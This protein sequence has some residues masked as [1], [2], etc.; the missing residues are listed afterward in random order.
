MSMIFQSYALWPHMTVTENVAYGLTLRRRPR[1]EIAKKVGAHPRHHQAVGAGRS[2][3]RRTVGRPAAARRARPRADRRAG[4]AAARRAAVQSRRQS[5]R[6]DALRGAPAA[7]RVP[8]HDGLRHPRPVGGDDHRRPDR[9]DERRQDRAGRHAG[10]D[11]RPA[12]L[13][14]RRP[15]HRLEQHRQGQGARPAITSRWRACRCAASARELIAGEDTAVSMRQH[16]ISLST[17]AAGS[18]STTS[19][20]QPSCATSF[21][22]TAATIWLSFPTRPSSA[23]SRRRKENVAQGTKIWLHLPPERCRALVG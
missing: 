10:G 6:G 21:S 15:L 14:I 4:N 23:W 20:R 3:S 11:L 12:A 16:E 5:A 13:G 17:A 22:A 2:L 19:F 18:G 7:R 1:E 8:L 9:G